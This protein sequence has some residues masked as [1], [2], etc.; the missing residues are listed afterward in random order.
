MMPN[1]NPTILVAAAP[2]LARNAELGRDTIGA[3]ALALALALAVNAAF[4]RMTR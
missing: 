1:P 3:T 2:A 4:A